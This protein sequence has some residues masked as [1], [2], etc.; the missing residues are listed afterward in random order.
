MAWPCLRYD[1]LQM[2]SL[3]LGYELHI[4]TSR[5]FFASFLCYKEHNFNT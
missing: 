4:N 1:K 5:T 3:K 2:Q